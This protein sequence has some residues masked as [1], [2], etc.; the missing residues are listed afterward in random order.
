MSPVYL[1][2]A[3]LAVAG[4]E[5]VLERFGRLVSP[6][7]RAPRRAVAGGASTKGNVHRG[8]HTLGR[9]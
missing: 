4:G 8:N 3:L 1:Q 9:G 5:R 2:M 6:R 7:K